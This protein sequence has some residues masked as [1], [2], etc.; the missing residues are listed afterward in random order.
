MSTLVTHSPA[1]AALYPCVLGK[2]EKL[3]PLLMPVCIVKAPP[4]WTLVSWLC[5]DNYLI[6]LACACDLEC[7]LVQYM[8][9]FA[10]Y[11]SAVTRREATFH[12]PWRVLGIAD[13][14]CSFVEWV[15]GTRILWGSLCGVD[16]DCM[17][18]IC[19]LNYGSWYD[20]VST[21]RCWHR[22]LFNVFLAYT[23]HVM[24]CIP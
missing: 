17:W 23:P 1:V 2:K 15:I 5:C 6:W 22:R 4:C 20:A 24:K 11:G 9:V 19:R 12:E 10:L 8:H 16:S 3:E 13:S 18:L 21:C 7:L 14:R